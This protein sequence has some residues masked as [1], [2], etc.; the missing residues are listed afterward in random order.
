MCFIW[1]LHSYFL[2]F[3]YECWLFDED[4]DGWM[5]TILGYILGLLTY[6][7]PVCAKTIELLLFLIDEDLCKLLFL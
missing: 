3:G 7:G 1:W 6:F 4:L 5:W 2:R